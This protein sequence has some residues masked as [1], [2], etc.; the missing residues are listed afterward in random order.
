MLSKITE[1]TQFKAQYNDGVTAAAYPVEI[2]LTGFGIQIED[3]GSVP[4]VEWAWRDIQLAEKI[5]HNRPIR[6][7]NRSI[8]GARLTIEDPAVGEIL[9]KNAGIN[10]LFRCSGQY[11]DGGISV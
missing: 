9:R 1:K 6:I 4:T 11:R 7:L 8:L 2:I 5:A 10:S 3:K